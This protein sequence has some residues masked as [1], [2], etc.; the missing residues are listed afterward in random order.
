[1]G[2]DDVQIVYIERGLGAVEVR[3]VLFG[4]TYRNEFL[5]RNGILEEL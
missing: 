1:M 2:V 3:A 5:L 4:K